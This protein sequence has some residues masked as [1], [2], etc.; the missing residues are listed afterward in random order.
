MEHHE[1]VVA[2]SIQRRSPHEW[3]KLI[4]K[5][6][7]IGWDEEAERLAQ[8]VRTLPIEQRSAVTLESA[9]TD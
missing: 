7:W 9:R 8:A 3:A 2:A 4:A 6:R 1:T 5:L